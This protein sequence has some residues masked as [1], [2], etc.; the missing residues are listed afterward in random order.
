[1][2]REV[3]LADVCLDL[4]DPSDAPPVVVVADQT[5]A[6]ERRAGRERREGEQALAIERSAQLGRTVT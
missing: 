2:R 1:V 4:D 6:E 5:P 3:L